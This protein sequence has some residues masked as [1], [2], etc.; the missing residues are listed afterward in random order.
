MALLAAETVIEQAKQL[1][2]ELAEMSN[3]E[4]V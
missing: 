3:L 2:N 4:T 1:A